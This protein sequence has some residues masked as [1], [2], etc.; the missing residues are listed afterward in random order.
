MTLRWN[1]ELCIEALRAELAAR[2]DLQARTLAN[3]AK[4]QMGRAHAVQVVTGAGKRRARAERRILRSMGIRGR[5]P[6]DARATAREMVGSIG[7]SGTRQYL[8]P[9]KPNEYPKKRTGALRESIISESDPAALEARWGLMPMPTA[10]G[11]TTIYGKHLE[12][13]TGRMHSRPWMSRANVECRAQLKAIMEKPL[14][15]LAGTPLAGVSAEGV[16][17]M[18]VGEGG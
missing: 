1:G 15:S 2:L 8:D 14:R 5:A 13:G 16:S 10:D 7:M 9:S 17:R 18:V 6:A 11:G 12:L 3:Y 4:K